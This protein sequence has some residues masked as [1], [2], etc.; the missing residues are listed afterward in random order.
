MNNLIKT[1]GIGGLL[2]LGCLLSGCSIPDQHSLNLVVKEHPATTDAGQNYYYV[3]RNQALADQMA[4]SKI[5]VANV[6]KR[7]IKKR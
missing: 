7:T 1:Q 2:M 5:T 4:M 3:S 6:K